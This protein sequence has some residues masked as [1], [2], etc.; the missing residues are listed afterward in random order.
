MAFYLDKHGI[1]LHGVVLSLSTV[2]LLPLLLPYLL[3]KPALQ[4]LCMLK[5]QYVAQILAPS[6]HFVS[7]DLQA[8]DNIKFIGTFVFHI[9]RKFHKPDS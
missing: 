4:I 9:R 2:T 5:F 3:L 6:S 8:T 7:G 1:R